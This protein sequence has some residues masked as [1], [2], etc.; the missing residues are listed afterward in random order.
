MVSINIMQ[1]GYW[2]HRAGSSGNTCSEEYRGQ[3]AFSEPESRA[4]RSFVT[5]RRDKIKLYLTFHSWGQMFLYPWG[6]DSRVVAK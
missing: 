3:A 1:S 5:P 2:G 6:Y 4:V